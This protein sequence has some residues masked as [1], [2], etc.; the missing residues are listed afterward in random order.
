M[1]IS[2]SPFYLI[3]HRGAAGER[4]E[5][6]PEGFQHA[7]TLDIDA[8]ELDIHE[9]SSNL[10][11][12]H[13]H[14]LDRLTNSKGLFES[15]PDPAGVRLNNGEAIPTLQQVLDLYW[16]KMPINVEIKAVTNLDLLLDRLGRGHGVLGNGRRRLFVMLDRGMLVVHGRIGGL[17]SAVGRLH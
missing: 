13:D 12:F 2:D 14:A 11:V 17:C 3:G 7:L 5:N 6:S 15:H 10:W 16:G 9:H 8:I 1:P 4:L